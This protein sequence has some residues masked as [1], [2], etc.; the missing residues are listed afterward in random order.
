MLREKAAWIVK[1]IKDNV[2]CTEIT[3]MMFVYADVG[4]RLDDTLIKEA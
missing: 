2:R 4:L 1:W 3:H